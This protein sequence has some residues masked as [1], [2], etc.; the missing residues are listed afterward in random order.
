M[1]VDEIKMKLFWV[2][3]LIFLNDSLILGYLDVEM[4]WAENKLKALFEVAG[5]EEIK[6]FSA[7]CSSERVK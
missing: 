3:I 7:C 5:L 1:C 4:N 6:H 2:V